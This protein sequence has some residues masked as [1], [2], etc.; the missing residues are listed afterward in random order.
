MPPKNRPLSWMAASLA[1][2]VSLVAGC[3]PQNSAVGTAAQTDGLDCNFGGDAVKASTLPEPAY[4]KSG[5]NGAIFRSSGVLTIGDRSVVAYFDAT[6]SIRIVILDSDLKVVGGTQL[7]NPM[8]SGMLGDGHQGVNIGYS[9]DGFLHLIGGAHGESVPFYFKLR[10]PSLERVEAGMQAVN[11][12]STKITYPQFLSLGDELALLVRD[13]GANGSYP[14]EHYDE[15]THKWVWPSSPVLVR[16]S[17]VQSLYLNTPGV[18]GLN[19][20]F[21]YTIRLPA[22]DEDDLRV[23]NTNFR[24]ISS[25]DGGRSWKSPPTFD[26]PPVKLAT[27]VRGDSPI[28]IPIPDDENLLN[29]GGGWLSTDGT[30][31]IGYMRDDDRGIPQLEVSGIDLTRGGVQ[32]SQVTDST[33]DFDL[34][35]KGSLSLPLSRP[36]VLVYRGTPVVVY[37]ESDSIVIAWPSAG[38]TAHWMRSTVCVGSLANWEPIIDP[39]AVADGVLNLYVQGAAQGVDDR[40]AEGQ[41]DITRPSVVTISLDA[42]HGKPSRIGQAPLTPDS[43]SPESLR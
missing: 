18:D 32:D 41:A 7:T 14:L 35:G 16:P 29:Q 6:E 10:W 30:Y 17:G 25:A 37:R 36:A 3:H 21:A 27:P 13:D 40:P 24:V 38:N 34:V 15:I 1:A 42:L 11:L 28:T 23:R 22:S 39:G 31:W 19:L 4:S 33:I 5:I 26:S 8:P 43:A 12:E 20:A 9:P 2:L